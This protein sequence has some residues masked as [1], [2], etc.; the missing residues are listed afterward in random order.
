MNQIWVKYRHMIILL[1]QISR[2][3]WFPYDNLAKIPQKSY[4]FPMFPLLNKNQTRVWLSWL[5]PAGFLPTSDMMML[6]TTLGAVF[7]AL[8]WMISGIP[9]T[10]LRSSIGPSPYLSSCI[11]LYHLIIIYIC[12]IHIYI[13]I[14]ILYIYMYCIVSSDYD[15]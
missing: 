15:W 13:Y 10:C 3:P 9:M 4:G 12:I 6:F 8:T 2:N 7:R 14:I 1:L 11:I 5:F